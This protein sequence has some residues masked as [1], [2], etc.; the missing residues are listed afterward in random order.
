MAGSK[1]GRQSIHNKAKYQKQYE[2][3]KGNKRR[4]LDKHLM[5]HPNDLQALKRG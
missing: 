5:E 3:T 4:A 2:I 1:K